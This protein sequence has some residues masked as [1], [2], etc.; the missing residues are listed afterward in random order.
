MRSTNRDRRAPHQR[1]GLAVRAGWA[2]TEIRQMNVKPAQMVP[3][4]GWIGS[5]T[6]GV[7]GFW[8]LLAAE[9]GANRRL[10]GFPFGSHLHCGVPAQ[11]R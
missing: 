8:Q 10:R 1:F 9:T 4:S 7:D 11:E 5:R 2:L 6:L 3:V